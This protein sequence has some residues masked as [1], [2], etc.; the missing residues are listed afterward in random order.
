MTLLEVCVDSA[1]GLLAACEAGADRIELCSALEL[2]GLTPSPGLLALAAKTGVATR[3]MV[4]PRAGDF[5]FTRDEQR[6]ME[7]DIA[8]IRATGIEGVVLGAS[9]ADG[10]VDLDCLAALAEASHGLKR[11]LHRAFDL[12][13]DLGE[14]IEAAIALGF[15]T[16]LTSGRAE[17]AIA[18]LGDIAEAHRLA[19]G[20]IAIM[21]G[22]GIKPGNV[23]TVLATVPLP[24]IHGSCSLPAPQDSVSAV[25]LGFASPGRRMT[26]REE[27]AALRVSLSR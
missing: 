6:Q 10:R 13:P 3:A 22:T 21:A 1:E 15:D 18:G 7:A 23:G 20:R 4:R 8:A 24:A 11:T 9:L 17:T 16:I 14:A 26:S 27:V 2:G 12:V 19:A 5:V 25:S